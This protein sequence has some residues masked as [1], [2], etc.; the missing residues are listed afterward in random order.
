MTAFKT[1]FGLYEYNIMPLGLCGGPG[2][3]QLYINDVLREYLDAFCTAYIDD[4]L[5]YSKSVKEHKIH[6]RKVLEALR[7]ARLQLDIGKCEF[8]V[9]ETTYLGLIISDKGIRM[10][11]QKVLAIKEWASPKNVRD[12]QAFVGFAN[13][14]RR[15][16]RGFSEIASPLIKL[17]RKNTVFA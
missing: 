10:D 16:V 4:I 14:Y 6:V 15:F 12:I 9:T 1:R 2:S 11:P 5:I 3:F 8:F 17:P 13:F 7:A